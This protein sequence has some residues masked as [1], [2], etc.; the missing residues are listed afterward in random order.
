MALELDYVAEPAAGLEML[1]PSVYG[2]EVAKQKAAGRTAGRTEQS[3]LAAVDQWCEPTTAQAVRELLNHTRSQ[4][5]FEHFYWGE[6]KDPS[7]TA[8]HNTARGQVQPWSLYTAPEGRT[9]WAPNF[10]WIYKSD[11][12]MPE[13]AV[14]VFRDRIS[15][16]PGAA[17]RLAE[18]ESRGWKARPSLLADPIF[19][20]PAG[21]PT[22][23][24]ALDEL[25]VS[26]AATVEARLVDGPSV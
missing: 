5:S 20:D 26:A 19:A 9:T 4:T 1:L 11:S 25:L 23:L 2:L 6:G 22:I 10:D 8:V 15:A 17:P 16:L 18:V 12:R 7:V 13:S 21:L 14:R 3:L 24:S